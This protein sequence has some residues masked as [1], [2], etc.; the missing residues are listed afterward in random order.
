MWAMCN[1]SIEVLDVFPLSAS[2]PN[3]TVDITHYREKV[4]FA[5]EKELKRYVQS[6]IGEKTK[7]VCVE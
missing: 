1:A 3:G 6:E 5:A 4:F 2:Y 7:P